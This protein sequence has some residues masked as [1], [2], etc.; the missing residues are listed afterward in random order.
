MFCF[1]SGLWMSFLIFV[2]FSLPSRWHV[3]WPSIPRWY[4]QWY[5]HI[6]DWESPFLS[7]L[8]PSPLP[9]LS[10][11]NRRGLSLSAQSGKP[12]LGHLA[13]LNPPQPWGKAPGDADLRYYI[14]LSSQW[15]WYK[16]SLCGSVSFWAKAGILKKC[17]TIPDDCVYS[18]E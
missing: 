12:D 17:V 9:R 5:W 7:Q 3:C 8:L 14:C 16:W 2:F 15:S 13:H 6:N 10:F 4:G 18:E 11:W 1:K